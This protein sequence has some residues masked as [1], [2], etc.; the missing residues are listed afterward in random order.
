MLNGETYA[1]ITKTLRTSPKL[2]SRVSFQLSNNNNNPKAIQSA[3]MGR[4]PKITPEVIKT[5]ENKTLEHP[6]MSGC[7]LSTIIALNLGI[8]VSKST[9]NNIRN[10]LKFR[11]IHPRRRQFMTEK[12]IQ[13]IFH[14][15]C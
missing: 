3:K 10:Q 15:N 1:Y 2:V 12:H 13:S 8:E 4:P 6:Q 5:V 11:F 9:V 7:Q 14:V